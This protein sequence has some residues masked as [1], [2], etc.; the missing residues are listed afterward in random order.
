MALTSKVRWLLKTVM[1][2][3]YS[4]ELADA[5][6]EAGE[7]GPTEIAAN[8]VIAAKIMSTNV[9]F[10]HMAAASINTAQFVPLAV[11]TGALGASSVTFEKMGL[12]SINTGQLVP[13][14]V[15]HE[16]LAPLSINTNHFVPLAVNLGALATLVAPAYI[17][18]A[19]GTIVSVGADQ[20]N[21]VSEMAAGDI[22]ICSAANAVPA[23]TNGISASLNATYTGL[24]TNVVDHQSNFQIS[25]QILRA[26]S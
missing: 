22:V 19:A 3:I 2:P 15:T 25:Y 21:A 14:S 7:I 12:L 17:V 23:A 16:V 5:V 13:N 20:V 1:G 24:Y 6:D 11:N 26:T 8:A 18:V 10:R 9:Q 4:K